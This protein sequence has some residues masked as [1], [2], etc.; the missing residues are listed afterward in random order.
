MYTHSYQ[1][2]CAMNGLQDGIANLAV[3]RAN[4]LSINPV[5]RPL[6]MEYKTWREAGIVWTHPI[7][8]HNPILPSKIMNIP[9]T[10]SVPHNRTLTENVFTFASALFAGLYLEPMGAQIY[11]AVM[12]RSLRRASWGVYVLV[13]WWAYLVW[14]FDVDRH[15]E[16]AWRVRSGV[17]RSIWLHGKCMG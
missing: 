4:D 10:P 13:K 8:K 16:R 17:L 1:L 2:S 3:P 5:N 11:T 14:C 12:L 15:W 9:H 7:K 6:W